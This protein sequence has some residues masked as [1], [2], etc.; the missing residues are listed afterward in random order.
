M[1]AQGVVSLSPNTSLSVSSEKE[2]RRP[3]RKSKKIFRED[4]LLRAT[5]EVF[6]RFA[7]G[8]RVPLTQKSNAGNSEA[9]GVRS[10]KIF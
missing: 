9:R 2:R 4:H 7:D 1:V 8:S 3:E 10:E 5:F 6:R